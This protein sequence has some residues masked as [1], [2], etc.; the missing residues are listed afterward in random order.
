MNR[1]NVCTCITSERL[2]QVNNYFLFSLLSEKDSIFV[3]KIKK[4]RYVHEKNERSSLVNY[5]NYNDDNIDKYLIQSKFEMT[6]VV[7]KNKQ[8]NSHRKPQAPI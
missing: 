8:M 6:P 1:Q 4:K 5:I 7:Q 3:K 2:H